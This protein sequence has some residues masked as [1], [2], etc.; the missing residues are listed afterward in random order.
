MQRSASAEIGISKQVR[1]LR[2]AVRP[3]RRG[4]KLSG[5][6][7]DLPRKIIRDV[8]F[9]ARLDQICGAQQLFLA[10]TQGVADGLLHL[11]V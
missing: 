11:D 7:Q 3:L 2:R 5:E 1:Q 6:F 8:R 10:C 4:W 9:I